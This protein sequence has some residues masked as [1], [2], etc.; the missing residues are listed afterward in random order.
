LPVIIDIYLNIKHYLKFDNKMEPSKS[1]KELNFD[2]MKMEE[3]F[4]D[5][6]GVYILFSINKKNDL[7]IHFINN[8]IKDIPNISKETSIDDLSELGKLIDSEDKEIVIKTIKDIK[9]NKFI[10][11][12]IFRLNIK[13]NPSRWFCLQVVPV[14]VKNETTY[15]SAILNDISKDK[16]IE[17][18]VNLH[19]KIVEEM[20]EGIILVR[21]KDDL[22]VYTNSKFDALFGFEPG[23]LFGHH[24]SIVYASKEEVH[25]DT[26]EMFKKLK[27]NRKWNGDIE[28]IKKDGSSFYATVNASTLDHPEFGEVC[29]CVYNDITERILSEQKLKQTTK[30]L[31]LERQELNEKNIALKEIMFQ[32]EN[33]KQLIREQI[34]TNIEN[35]ILPTLRRIANKTEKENLQND[36]MNLEKDLKGISSSF[37]NKIKKQY[38]TLTPREIE[39]SNLIKNGQTSKDISQALNLSLLTVH[40]HRE[41]IRK[42]LKLQNKN[43]NLTTYLQSM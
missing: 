41:I 32:I 25:K 37:I 9:K 2:N 1:I 17:N 39:I 14:F 34:N 21:S 4:Q 10:D 12:L 6:S 33:E 23:E 8:N 5:F 28:L 19:S 24:V 11:N 26:F 20:E 16:L 3:L 36:I 7:K 18:S 13:P 22:I 35:A 29:L 43:I 15:W 31:E 42:K 30:T 40:K 27:K 38:S